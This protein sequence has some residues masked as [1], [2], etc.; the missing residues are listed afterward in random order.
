MMSLSPDIDLTVIRCA[1]F[2]QIL[3]PWI[4]ILLRRHLV[5]NILMG[6]RKSV[7]R[8]KMDQPTPDNSNDVVERCDV[9]SSSQSITGHSNGSYLNST[10]CSNITL[11]GVNGSAITTISNGAL[12]TSNGKCHVG[13]T[14]TD[15]WSFTSLPNG[16]G[17]DRILISYTML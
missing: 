10:H 4:Y 9:T 17:M 14:L 12:V 3:D 8:C 13:Q 16:N 1:A 2:N 7:C 11:N 15:N 5:F 6:L